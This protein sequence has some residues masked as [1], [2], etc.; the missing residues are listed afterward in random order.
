MAG[1]YAVA[2]A[3]YEDFFDHSLQDQ[4]AENN[5]Y[6]VR[7]SFCLDEWARLAE[8]HPKA[9]QR[10]EAKAKETIAEL[11]RTRRPALFHDFISINKYL[12]QERT[13]I[14]L[15]LKY[16]SSD[17]SLAEAISTTSDEYSQDTRRSRRVSPRRRFERGSLAA[18]AG[19]LRCL[20]PK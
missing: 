1:D 12:G 18:A 17:R 4:G 16:H 5:Y 11:E 6:G 2:L 9:L 7:L 14:D 20:T 3:S 19:P 8:K 13:S 10:L 15:F